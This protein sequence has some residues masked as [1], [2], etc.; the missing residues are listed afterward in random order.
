MFEFQAHRNGTF[1]IID[2]FFIEVPALSLNEG[3]I[4]IAHGRRRR[5]AASNS[6][7]A[8]Q[9]GVSISNNGINY[10]TVTYVTVLDARCQKTSTDNNGDTIVI[11]SVNVQ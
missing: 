3:L 10:G 11:L 2:E 5:T 9:Y 1:V 8:R 6:V 4:D 7:F